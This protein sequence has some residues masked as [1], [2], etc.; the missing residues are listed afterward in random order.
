MAARAGK[1]ATSRAGALVRGSQTQAAMQP[2][3]PFVPLEPAVA[4]RSRGSRTLIW[5]LL[6]LPV[7]AAAILLLGT[8]ALVAFAGVDDY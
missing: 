8:C 6:W 5:M 1:R 3:E 4:T 2:E 7:C